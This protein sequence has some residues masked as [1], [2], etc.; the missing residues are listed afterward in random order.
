[1]TATTRSGRHLGLLGLAVALG[2]AGCGG[3]SDDL[4]TDG[5]PSATTSPTATATVSTPTTLKGVPVYWVAESRGSFAL[6]RELRD[7][8]DTGGPVASAVAAM[9]RMR[10]LDPDY[11]TPWR[12]ASRVTAAQSGEAITVDLSADALSSTQVGSE[13][14]ERAV[15][16]LVYTAT[17]AAAKAGTPATTVTITVDGGPRDAWGAVRLGEPTRRAA[18]SAVQAQAWVTSPQEGQV[19]PA[20]TV[21]F[22]GFGTSPE[23]TFGWK[24]VSSTGATVAHGSVMGGTGDGGY[25]EVTF[26]ATLAAGAYTVELSTDDPS[27][28]AEGNGPATDDKSFAVR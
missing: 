25:G 18:L 27:G 1:M 24:V 2:V 11:T 20:G 22:T 16:Q 10:P 21:T 13:L 19:V 12:P 26:R 15:Q 9:T 14:A 6:Y 3:G 28:G 7:V 5:T 4:S 17:A 8:P 23:A